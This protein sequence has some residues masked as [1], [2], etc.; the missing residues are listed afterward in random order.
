MCDGYV[1]TINW[2]NECIINRIDQENID[3]RGAF[4]L[5]GKST[6]MRANDLERSSSS[7]KFI[8]VWSY[9]EQKRGNLGKHKCLLQRKIERYRDENRKSLFKTATKFRKRHIE[10]LKLVHNN[11][12]IQADKHLEKNGKMGLT[13]VSIPTLESRFWIDSGRNTTKEEEDC[14]G[15]FSHEVIICWS[16]DLFLNQLVFWPITG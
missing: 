12:M 16:V 9:P 13:S 2:R 11:A 1:N 6:R 4:G 7:Q 15:E 8:L 5:F 14:Q 10:V 3:R